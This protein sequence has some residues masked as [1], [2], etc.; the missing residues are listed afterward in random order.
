MYIFNYTLLYKNL[1]VINFESNLKY[2]HHSSRV[3]S[4]DQMKSKDQHYSE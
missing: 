2:I 3:S 4:C 1:P